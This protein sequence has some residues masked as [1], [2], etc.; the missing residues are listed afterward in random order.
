MTLL[1]GSA[2]LAWLALP[3]LFALLVQL[4]VRRS[5]LVDRDEKRTL[6]L[7]LAPFV[8]GI[9]LVLTAQAMPVEPIRIEDGRRGLFV[10]G[11][12]LPSVLAQPLQASWPNFMA[13]LAAGYGLLTIFRLVRWARGVLLL[14]RLP[15]RASRLS[16]DDADILISKETKSPLIHPS[17]AVIFP[18]GFFEASSEHEAAMVLAHERAHHDRGDQRYFIVLAL[19]DAVFWFHPAVL[20]QTRR[21]RLAAELACDAAACEAFP[22]HRRAYADLILG[23]LRGAEG[24]D[25]ACAPTIFS[26]RV[27][28][29]IRMRLES[30]M[31]STDAPLRSRAVLGLVA[32]LVLPLTLGQWA[33]AQEALS[34][35]FSVSPVELGKV[36]SRYGV[37]RDPWNKHLKS[38]HLGLDFAAPLGT[39]VRAP[40]AGVISR[41]SPDLEGYGNLLEITHAGGVVTRYAQLKSFKVD[42][43]DRVG[44]G[45]VIAKVGS[46]GRS[47]GPHLH[48]E[49]FIDGD[50]VDPETVV[51]VS[52]QQLRKFNTEH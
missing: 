48:L 38:W 42:L 40:G 3:C 50:R 4:A 32:A 10:D 35:E 45:Q 17:G 51:P 47:T 5:P 39:P 9:A 2:L 28:G 44:A 6:A 31:R 14:Y 24:A 29:D 15:A 19:I 26:N 22:Q 21:C 49:V 52:A 36:T 25:F 11:P 43:G 20:A 27:H 30:I 1:T 46:S 13:L 33:T 37:R 18:V 8:L 16:D 7:V 41:V 34:T 12:A 23:S